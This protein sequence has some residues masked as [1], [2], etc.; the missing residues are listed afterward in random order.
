LY[1]VS[2]IRRHCHS[3]P[4]T[5]FAILTITF[6]EREIAFNAE[7]RTWRVVEQTASRHRENPRFGI[8]VSDEDAE[9][10]VDENRPSSI[11]VFG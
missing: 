7:G 2:R 5:I 4:V 1:T 8:G 11:D 6:E 10:S 3:V 9:V